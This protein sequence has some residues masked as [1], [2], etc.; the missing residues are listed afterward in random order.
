MQ[1]SHLSSDTGPGAGL[2]GI[3]EKGAGFEQLATGFEFVEGPA[4]HPGDRRGGLRA[5]YPFP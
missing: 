4:W 3:L 5:R 2:T 1:A